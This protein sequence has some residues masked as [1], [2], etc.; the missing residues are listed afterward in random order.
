MYYFTPGG[1]GGNGKLRMPPVCVVKIEG[2]GTSPVPT[3]MCG[4]VELIITPTPVCKH[5]LSIYMQI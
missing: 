1:V 2:Q 5:L 3:T 4:M